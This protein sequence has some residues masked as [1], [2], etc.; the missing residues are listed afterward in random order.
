MYGNH[1]RL[2]YVADLRVNVGLAGIFMRSP[3][4]YRQPDDDGQGAPTVTSGT[5][6]VDRQSARPTN[7]RVP[8]EVVIDSARTWSSQRCCR[9]C[10]V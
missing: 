4:S 1:D 10:C 9:S 3:T 6:C 7:R 8:K 2:V 5:V